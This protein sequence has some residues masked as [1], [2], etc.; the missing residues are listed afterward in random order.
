ML[1]TD[2]V[3]REVTEDAG[4]RETIR[5]AFGSDVFD[6]SGAL[7]RSVLGRIVFAH[8]EKRQLLNGMVHPE[9][10]RRWHAWRAERRAAGEAAVVVIP[11][12]YEVDATEG[13]DEVWCI[14]APEEVMVQ[15]LLDRGHTEGE[16]RERMASQMPLKEKMARADRVIEND[17]NLTAFHSRLRAA[18]NPCFLAEGAN[19]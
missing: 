15:R 5:E 7:D 16:A 9:I 11:L 8:P 14:A 3:A 13:W 19:P 17:D 4:I 6:A 10:S 12:L 1:D 2:A 18:F